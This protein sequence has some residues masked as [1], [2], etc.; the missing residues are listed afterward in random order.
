MALITASDQPCRASPVHRTK[1]RH[2]GPN[3]INVASRSALCTGPVARRL[4][5]LADKFDAHSRTSVDF[6]STRPEER[7]P[8]YR[9]GAL[10]QIAYNAVMHRGNAP[11]RA[12]RSMTSFWQ[13][14]R[15]GIERCGADIVLVDV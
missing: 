15:Q 6:T 13:V 8:T 12:F 11:Y 14:I 2:P 5:R 1:L 9:G 10:R 7:R 4:D 3:L